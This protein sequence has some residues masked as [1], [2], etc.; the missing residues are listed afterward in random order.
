LHFEEGAD[1]TGMIKHRNSRSWDEQSLFFGGVNG[2]QL[3]AKGNLTAAGDARRWGI[4][5]VVS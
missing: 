4:G 1:L 2:I 3:D 5:K